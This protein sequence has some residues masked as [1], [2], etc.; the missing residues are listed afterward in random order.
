MAKFWR[1][2]MIDKKVIAK[3]EQEEYINRLERTILELSRKPPEPKPCPCVEYIKGVPYIPVELSDEEVDDYWLAHHRRD[4]V[5]NPLTPT[6][7]KTT[8]REM[9]EWYLK[10]RKEYDIMDW[11]KILNDIHESRGFK[12]REVKDENNTRTLRQEE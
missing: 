5:D 7:S 2:G 6:Q 9:Y 12:L 8:I 3:R 10:H 11:E 1:S 4:V